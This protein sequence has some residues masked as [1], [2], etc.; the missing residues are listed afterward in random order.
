MVDQVARDIRTW[1]DAGLDCGQVAVNLSPPEF[2][3]AELADRVLKSLARAGIPPDC[4]EVEVT[5]TVFLGRGS[6]QVGATLERLHAHGVRIAL[7]DFGTGF[8]SLSHLKR[9]PIDLLKIDQSFIR[10]LE[11]DPDDAAIVAAVIGLGNSLRLDVTAEGVETTGQAEFLRA[12]GCDNAQGF[13]FAKPM[14]GSRVPWF[15]QQGRAT[16][17]GPQAKPIAS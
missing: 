16:S 8:A 4:F 17:D 5:E 3:N 11:R 10:D 13:L 7:D 1:R 9:F 14:A 15:L 12:H 2:L 6:D